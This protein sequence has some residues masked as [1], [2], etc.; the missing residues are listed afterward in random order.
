MGQKAD[1]VNADTLKPYKSPTK[2]SMRAGD[3]NTEGNYGNEEDYNYRG[4]LESEVGSRK[5]S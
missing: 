1:V 4:Q 2:H 5:S 3:D